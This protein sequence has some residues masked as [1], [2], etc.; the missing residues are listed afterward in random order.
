MARRIEGVGGLEAHDARRA[1][2]H[3]DLG[4]RGV[5]RERGARAGIGARLG[6]EQDRLRALG[7][8]VRERGAR[9]LEAG[10]GAAVRRGRR[11]CAAPRR[12]RA[13]PDRGSARRSAPSFSHPVLGRLTLRPPRAVRLEQAVRD[14]RPAPAP[15]PRTARARA[16]AG[17]APPARRAR[18]AR[19]G[20]TAPAAPPAAARAASSATAA[21]EAFAR[22]RGEPDPAAT[23]SAARGQRAARRR[24]LAALERHRHLPLRSARRLSASGGSPAAPDCAAS[25]SAERTREALGGAVGVDDQRP[26]AAHRGAAEAMERGRQQ[27]RRQRPRRGGRVAEVESAQRLELER[28]RTRPRRSPAVGRRSGERWAAG[29]SRPRSVLPSSDREAVELALDHRHL[30]LA[31]HARGRRPTSG[32][33]G[34][35]PG[36]DRAARSPLARRPPASWRAACEVARIV[37][38]RFL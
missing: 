14:W 27:L 5:E 37:L 3:R 36:C 30:L 26:A 29:R 4:R 18:A 17:G 9:R 25:T 7:T 23:C 24:R 32:R 1:R 33:S 13:A 8:E 21:L 20:R 34:A 31:A 35:R 11:S 6:R 19:G 28:R 2:Q 15:P 38:A 12:R 22:R 10:A 16:P